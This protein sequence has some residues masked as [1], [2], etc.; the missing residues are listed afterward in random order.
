MAKRKYAVR[1]EVEPWG[2]PV[3]VP[4]ANVQPGVRV[5]SDNSGYCDLLFV[6]SVLL[7]DAEEIASVLL[8]SSESD[9][10]SRRLLEAVRDQID[11]HLEHH[12]DA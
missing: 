2:K 1:Y 4:T 12:A 7:N 11:H 5:T 8:L 9:G 3:R 10:L 6:G